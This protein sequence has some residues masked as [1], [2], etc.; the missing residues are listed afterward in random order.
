M[1]REQ[2]NVY[3][4]YSWKFKTIVFVLYFRR[5]GLKI[6]KIVQSQRGGYC[7]KILFSINFVICV[8]TLELLVGTYFKNIFKHFPIV[9]TFHYPY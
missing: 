5:N 7:S 8:T 3:I 2:N 6:Y 1:Y 9:G 4:S